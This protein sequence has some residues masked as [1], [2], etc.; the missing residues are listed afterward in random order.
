MGE[1]VLFCLPGRIPVAVEK[2]EE[3]AES[4]VVPADFP[5][6]KKFLVQVLFYFFEIRSDI[7]FYGITSLSR[8]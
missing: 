6:R 7:N 2:A 3:P 5:V 4:L 8:C 1:Q